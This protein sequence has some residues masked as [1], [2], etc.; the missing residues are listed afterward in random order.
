MATTIQSLSASSRKSARDPLNKFRGSLVMNLKHVVRWVRRLLRSARMPDWFETY[1]GRFPVQ[2][3][4]STLQN[5]VA[6]FV[7]LREHLKFIRHTT[8]A[9]Q[10]RGFLLHYF[11]RTIQYRR[12]QAGVGY[13][14]RFCLSGLCQDPVPHCPDPGHSYHQRGLQTPGIQRNPHATLDGQP[15]YRIHFNYFRGV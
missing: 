10:A 1:A 12:I 9:L 6:V 14:F 15:P 3:T 2:C 13:F 4:R 7:P 5:C 8:R 11:C